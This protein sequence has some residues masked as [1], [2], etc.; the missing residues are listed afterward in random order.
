MRRSRITAP[1]FEPFLS[2]R[3]QSR[4]PPAPR[5]RSLPACAETRAAYEA[6]E[7][8]FAL[9]EALIAARRNASLTQEQL[10]QAMGATQAGVALRERRYHPPVAQIQTRVPRFL[11]IDLSCSIQC[12]IRCIHE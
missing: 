3:A 4:N 5:R 1:D 2:F 10:A 11:Y 9:A 6:L 7:S 12:N 8:E